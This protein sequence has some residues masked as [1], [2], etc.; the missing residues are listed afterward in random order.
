MGF[1][2]KLFGRHGTATV[3]PTAATPRECAHGLL[4]PRWDN[5]DDMGDESKASSWECNSCGEH[6]PTE[7]AARNDSLAKDRFHRMFDKE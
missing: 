1:I 3:E 6:F 2:D 7:E 4:A 5:P